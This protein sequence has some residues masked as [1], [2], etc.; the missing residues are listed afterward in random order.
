[1]DAAGIHSAGIIGFTLYGK[2][3]VLYRQNPHYV[4]NAGSVTVTGK[5]VKIEFDT[6]S[7][8]GLHIFIDVTYEGVKQ[9]Y[10]CKNCLSNSPSLQLGRLYLDVDMNGNKNLPG[11]SNCQTSCEFVL[12]GF[13]CTATEYTVNRNQ[14]A[15][16]EMTQQQTADSSWRLAL[17]ADGEVITST[18]FLKVAEIPTPF[19]T[20]GAVDMGDVAD[21][22][23]IGEMKNIRI[24]GSNIERIRVAPEP[25]WD[26]EPDYDEDYT[27]QNCT[28]PHSGGTVGTEPVEFS[29][30]SYI[31]IDGALQ[32]PEVDLVPTSNTETA[33]L[34]LIPCGLEGQTVDADWL[35]DF[36]N[37]KMHDADDGFFGYNT[38]HYNNY[39]NPNILAHGPQINMAGSQFYRITHGSG[40]EVCFRKSCKRALPYDPV[41]RLMLLSVQDIIT[42]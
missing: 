23:V 15:N 2:E 17:L 33:M 16:I 41:F 10:F 5:V 34:P 26:C 37:L 6:H 38:R 4:N 20:T 21:F 35:P 12:G 3:G 22:S 39:L 36:E 31:G 24:S 18:E 40:K 11:A 7:N 29:Y 25:D 19:I 8:D 14:W 9:N 1:M 32:L 28:E 30:F 27:D 42:K 13:H